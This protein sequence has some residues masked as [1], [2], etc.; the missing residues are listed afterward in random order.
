MSPLLLT[1]ELG[2]HAFYA[3][4]YSSTRSEVWRWYWRSWFNPKGLWRVHVKLGLLS[5]VVFTA[6][7]GITPFSLSRF[8]LITG[9]SIVGCVVLFPLWPQVR[10]KP[11][12]RQLIIDPD[13][14]KTNIG[15]ISG[16]CRWKDVRSIEDTNG[17]IVITG[18]NGNAFIVPARGFTS[19]EAREEFLRAARNWLDSAAA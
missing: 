9:I 12:E 16:E 14:L 18:I 10:F 1:R 5:A 8:L 19:E 4:H 17:A 13:G 15:K 11:A 7:S 6:I 2:S 3:V